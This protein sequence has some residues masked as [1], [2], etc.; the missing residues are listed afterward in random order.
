LPAH[1]PDAIRLVLDAWER[2]AGRLDYVSN[3]HPPTWPDGNDVE[4]M[5]LATL[6]LA[7]REAAE[8]H[9]R[10]HTTPF[11]WDHPERFR[12]ANVAW[13]GGRDLSMTYRLTVDYPEDYVLVRAGYE[14]LWSLTGPSSRS[15]RRR[16]PQQNPRTCEHGYVGVN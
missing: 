6:E 3:L 14:A 2:G 7:A 15:A 5:S 1:R 4:V 9:E 8:P 16:V 13:P 11:L 12:I 10:E